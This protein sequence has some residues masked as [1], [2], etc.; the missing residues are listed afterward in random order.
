MINDKY[1]LNL[2]RRAEEILNRRKEKEQ[3]DKNV[4]ALLDELTLHQ[5]ELELQN[6]HLVKMYDELHESHLKY[7]DL[8]NMAP[9]A[10]FTL[11][12]DGLIVDVNQ[13]GLDLF[14]MKKTALINHSLSRF[15]A[16]EYQLIFSQFRQG[17]KNY[18]T[19]ETCEL[20][21]SRWN[22]E[23]FD[24]LLE[25]R[26]TQASH[27]KEEQF[28]ICVTDITNRKAQDH[29]IHMKRAKMA[30]IDRMRSMNE[31]I[32]SM[33]RTQNNCLT[34]MSNYI[35]GCIRRFESDNYNP[36]ELA[37]MM[38]KIAV[39]TNELT[40]GIQQ[41]RNLSS[42]SILRYEFSNL[43][44]TIED[45]ISIINSELSEY[46]IDVSYD[47]MQTLP[48]VKIDSLHIQQVLVN[49]ARNSVEAMRDAKVPKPRLLVETCLTDNN[50]VVVSIIDNGP[51]FNPTNV[52]KIFETHFTT[53]AYAMGLGLPTSRT[54]V[55]KHGGQLT[56][57]LNPA[58]G[59]HFLLTLPC[60]HSLAK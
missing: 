48:Q 53:K 2:R 46:P 10:Y 43:S 5:I 40:H 19:S 28:L 16:A 29:A 47:V 24:A 52:E 18:D 33:T 3:P 35:N 21:L 56:A 36:A 38:K 58:G 30:S 42:K 31:Q 45:A 12:I 57:A 8:Y 11:N 51:G 25:C 17:I 32:H 39:Q 49:L 9:M 1:S 23:E 20:K 41:V 14:S 15:I 44:Q 37:Q 27:T 4:Y 26:F 50:E 13:A 22:G 59:A 55:E 7:I 54:I 34:I 6:E 60:H